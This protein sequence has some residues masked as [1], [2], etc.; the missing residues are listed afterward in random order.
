LNPK[1]DEVLQSRLRITHVWDKDPGAA[2]QFGEEFGVEV[3][4]HYDQ[5]V[6]KVDAVLQTGHKAGYWSYEL[7]KPFLTTVHFLDG[8]HGSRATLRVYHE[9]G[10]SDFDH[11]TIDAQRDYINQRYQLQA[12]TLFNM[13][14]LFETR[15]PGFPI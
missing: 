5:M 14:Q 2:R 7:T 4:E 13:Q 10:C 8:H 3:V 6:G 9:G 12:K 1:P 11:H 15:K